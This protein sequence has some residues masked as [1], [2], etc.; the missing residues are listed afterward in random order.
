[1][2]LSA[3]TNAANATIPVKPASQILTLERGVAKGIKI[4]Y[5]R[6]GAGNKKTVIFLQGSGPGASAWLNFRYNVQAFADAGFQVLLPD[7]PG[8]GDSDKPELDYTLDFFVDVVTEFA[9]QLDIEQFSLVGNSL[10]GAVS[11]GVALAH[12]ARVTRLVLMGCGGLEDQITYFQKMEGIQAMTKV[13]LGS[14]E[15]TPA[16]LKQVLQLIVDDKKHVTDE[17]ITER[18]RI[19]Q[20]Q[21]PAVF[22]RMVIPNLSAR[23][24]EIQCPVLGFWGAKDRFCPLSGAET[25][26]TG[27]KQAEMITLSNAGHWVMI[28]HADLFN[29]RSIEFLGS[30]A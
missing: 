25:L 16:Y 5:T 17:L 18:F 3:S 24:P 14:P 10:G 8:F 15:F 1:M 13:P 28:E 27:C 30:E 12:P 11:L 6:F 29:R 26:V 4:D 9:D 21:T 7:L 23:L 2:T 22:K 20:T 19:L